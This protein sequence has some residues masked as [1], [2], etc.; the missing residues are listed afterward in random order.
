MCSK[1]NELIWKKITDSLLAP[2]TVSLVIDLGCPQFGGKR[3]GFFMKS[4]PTL[5]CSHWLEYYHFSF[6]NGPGQYDNQ[7]TA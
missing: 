3:L 7:S 1:I 6:Y 4:R 2:F 5:S